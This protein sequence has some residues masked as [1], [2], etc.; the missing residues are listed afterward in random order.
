MNNH[1]K[2]PPEPG[3]LT[4][5]RKQRE[6]TAEF[7]KCCHT[8]DHYSALGECRLVGEIPPPDFVAHG[9]RECPDYLEEI[10]F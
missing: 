5:W 4:A 7:P 1:N 9:S 3:F 10:P 2:R 8:C 6:E